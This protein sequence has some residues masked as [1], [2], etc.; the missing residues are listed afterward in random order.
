MSVTVPYL[1]SNARRNHWRR[2]ASEAALALPRHALTLARR[3][4]PTTAP[5]FSAAVPTVKGPFLSLANA[6][7][8]RRR[9]AVPLNVPAGRPNVRELL[10][11]IPST[12]GEIL[13]GQDVQV[14]V[15]TS[16]IGRRGTWTND[17]AVP[18][19][20][21]ASDGSFD[22]GNLNP[23]QSF[24]LTFSTAGAYAYICQYHAGMTGT[25]VVQ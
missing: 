23:G 16:R 12:D 14:V 3:E 2:V 20:A 22:S 4:S 17:D 21:T 19:T 18:H 8:R 9:E 13:A 1:P 6:A 11:A 15:N 24:S 7:A 10:S 25:I 5:E